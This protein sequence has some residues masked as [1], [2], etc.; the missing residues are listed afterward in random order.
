[1]ALRPKSSHSWHLLPSLEPL[2]HHATGLTGSAHDGGGRLCLPDSG[3][4]LG[5]CGKAPDTADVL[6]EHLRNQSAVHLSRSGLKAQCIP[7]EMN[8]CI[9]SALGTLPLAESGE[10]GS[11]DKKGRRGEET[12]R[13]GPVVFRAG[14]HIRPSP[15]LGGAAAL[16]MMPACFIRG[17][18]KDLYLGDRCC[19]GASA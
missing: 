11:P 5:V 13:Q 9:H 1:M 10:Q 12:C 15:G 14:C 18:E 4:P 17:E 16:S 3:L 6:C 19:P 8:E 7:N 2:C